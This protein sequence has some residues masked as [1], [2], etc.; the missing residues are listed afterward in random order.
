[1]KKTIITVIILLALAGL[2]Y[3]IWK[4]WNEATIF[5]FD[6]VSKKI[7]I[8][9]RGK[10]HII[11][12]TVALSSGN[13]TYEVEGDNFIVKENGKVIKTVSIQNL[14]TGKI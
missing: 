8:R 1:M 13:R 3:W 9:T 12:P 4:R 6:V 11:D 7:Y 14:S 10:E 5:R 2:F